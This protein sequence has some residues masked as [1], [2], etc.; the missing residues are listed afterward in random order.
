[1][2]IVNKSSFY[3]IIAWQMHEY[4]IQTRYAFSNEKTQHPKCHSQINFAN[5]LFKFLAW[6]QT[7]GVVFNKNYSKFSLKLAFQVYEK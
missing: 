2:Q 6:H 7:S 4:I 1:M 3:G 5:F